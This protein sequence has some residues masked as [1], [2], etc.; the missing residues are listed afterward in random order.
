[1]ADLSPVAANVLGSSDQRVDK[2]YLAGATMTAGQAVYLDTTQTPPR[3][4][5][6][7]C[8]GSALEA[9]SA[10]VGVAQHGASNGQPLAVQVGGEIDLGL[11]ATEA[12]VYV[13][14][15]TA[16]NIMPVTDLVTATWYC[17]I[18]GVGNGD[19]NIDLHPYASGEQVP[20]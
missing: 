9:G 18:L 8:D 17:T 4:E 5:L 2:S 11:T 12:V 16:G 10:G 15:N 20:A 13:I 1:M 14:S 19:G 7:Q 3:W 6:A